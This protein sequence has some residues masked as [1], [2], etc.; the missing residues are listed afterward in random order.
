MFGRDIMF[1]AFLAA[2]FVYDLRHMEIPDRFTLPGMAVA[3]AANVYL[4]SSLTSLLVGGAMVGGFFLLQY[5]LSR[6]QWIGSGDIRLG[7]LMGFMLGPTNAIVA[8]F[9]AYFAGALFGLA[10]MVA[11]KASAKTPIP[12]G[13]FLS[14]ATVVVLLTGDR[15]AETYLRMVGMG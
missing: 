5:V 15:L 8:L 3:L 10:L 1:V 11:R 13:T 7:F 2:I 9:L 6:G 14:A 12:F 4:G